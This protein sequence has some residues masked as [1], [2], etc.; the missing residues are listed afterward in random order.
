M[1]TILT[2][3]ACLYI[4]QAGAQTY[5]TETRIQQIVPERIV[6]LS[7]SARATIEGNTRMLIPVM[8]PKGTKSWYY[9]FSTS[10]EATGT[11]NLNLLI[12]LT[13]FLSG[14]SGITQTALRNLEVPTGAKNIDAFLLDRYNAD[15]FL[16]K[17][18]LS[19]NGYQYYTEGSVTNTRQALVPVNGITAG[20]F[21]IGLRN[22]GILDGVTV[23]IEVV[24]EVNTSVYNDIW[25]AANIDFLY[26]DCIKRFAVRTVAAEQICGCFKD[27]MTD[28]FSPAAYNA[29][30]VTDRHKYGDSY[31]DDCAKETGNKS[32]IEKNKR[33][34]E[35]TEVLQGQILVNDYEAIAKSYSELIELGVDNWEVYNGLGFCQLCLKKYEDAKQTLT[36]GLSKSPEEL[37][38]LGN[39]G[40]YYILT[41]QYDRAIEIFQ[42]NRNKKLADGRRFKQAVADDI[43]E[44]RR[45]GIINPDF[46][47]VKTELGIN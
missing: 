37:F 12:Q 16:N 13:A 47:R 15:L 19:G 44:F 6:S 36:K 17:S 20:V 22:P 34:K 45:L 42:K 31:I 26:S 33:I 46:D 27:K 40:E 38:L 23:T 14:S 30:S 21:Y 28:N 3:C 35:I 2:L 4:I 29:L 8:L 18:D 25:S 9:S 11:R 5:T 10:T 43:K 24:A 41:G 39:L 7:G 32:A 1:K